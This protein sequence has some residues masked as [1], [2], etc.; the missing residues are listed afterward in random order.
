MVHPFTAKES[1]KERQELLE[2]FE[3]GDLHAL[4]A[5]RCLDEGVDVPATRRAYMLASSSNPRQFVQRRGRILR[6][7]PGKDYAV[8]HDFIVRP[9]QSISLSADE[10][11]FRIERQLVKKELERVNTFA[12]AAENYPDVVPD[13]IPSSEGYIDDLRN[14]F[15]LQAI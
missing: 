11:R 13:W 12:E 1:D 10:K 3:K 8:I 5:I 4:V 9:P 2:D 14:E 6:N 7:H 15:D